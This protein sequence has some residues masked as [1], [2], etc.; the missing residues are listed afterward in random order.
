MPGTTSRSSV[1][2]PTVKLAG[3]T[4]RCMYLRRGRRVFSAR[5]RF[6][7][8]AVP[9]A[10]AEMARKSR[11][12]ACGQHT[13]PS[14]VQ[15]LQRVQHMHPHLTETCSAVASVCAMKDRGATAQRTARVVS[16]VKRLLSRALRSSASVDPTRCG[17]SMPV[18]ATAIRGMRSGVKPA[19]LH[20]NEEVVRFV[21]ALVRAVAEELAHKRDVLQALKRLHARRRQS[22]ARD[23]RRARNASKSSWRK[24][25]GVCAPAAR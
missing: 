9:D 11:G 17:D 4:S 14:A 13:A 12:R 18:S 20:R 16:H 19:H 23:A 8:D 25:T 5:P 15:C 6:A 3:L 1:P 7:R 21:A 2:K 22:A 10:R 24:Q